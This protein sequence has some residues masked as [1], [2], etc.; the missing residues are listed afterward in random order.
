MPNLALKNTITEHDFGEDQSLYARIGG[1]PTLERVHR[2]LY[3]KI[4]TH[5]NFRAFFA[6]TDQTHQENQQTDFMAMALGGPRQYGGR[7]PDGAHRHLYITEELFEL[8]HKILAETEHA[9]N[10]T[11]W[12]RLAIAEHSNLGMLQM[13]LLFRSNLDPAAWW[14]DE[15]AARAPDVE[16]RE[17][18]DIGAAEDIEFALVW[19][20]D[21]GMLA[22]L[23]NL[24]A[25]FTL[26]AGID[27]LLGD[28]DLPTHLPMSR[29]IDSEM[30]KRMTEYVL[31]HVLR[32]HRRHDD[33]DARQ[34][35]GEWSELSQPAAAARRIGVMGLGELGGAAARAL[36]SLGFDVAGYSR[37]AK[38]IDGVACFHGSDG[39]VAFLAQT[40]ILVCLLPLT[41]ETAGI[42]DARLF[43]ALPDGA[44]LI[45]AA[46]GAHLNQAD[47][48]AALDR[49]RLA[50]ATLD[51]FEQEPLP[52]DH[53][54]WSHPAITVT[55][56][57]AAICDPG[58]AAGQIAEN[59][60]RARAGDTLVNAVDLSVGY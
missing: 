5:S 7:L 50:G 38:H 52:S 46:R 16:F 21:P 4:F 12:A 45:N 37:G 30:T 40:Q 17:W 15:L 43:D 60:R 36:V 32:Y 59:I 31:S 23:P 27:H 39:L 11:R 54:F 51:V 56:H 2:A 42:L 58:S 41:N 48:L 25:I 57:I 24:R 49:G 26:G 9:K 29:M 1:R 19:N 6:K 3:N 55:P 34:R 33:Y 13:A 18:P 10:W 35:R 28:P 22:S 14:R 47:F 44:R 8:R 20:P 53:P